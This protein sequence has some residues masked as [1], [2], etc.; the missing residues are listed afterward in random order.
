MNENR[1]PTGW[2]AF[3]T[4]FG[5]ILLLIGC[6]AL[7]GIL[8]PFAGLDTAQMELV[9]LLCQA[10]I[11]GGGLL[12]GSGICLLVVRLLRYFLSY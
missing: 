2:V 5:G 3:I 6:L 8:I 10:G 9:V 12:F 4:L 1:I 7:K 11:I